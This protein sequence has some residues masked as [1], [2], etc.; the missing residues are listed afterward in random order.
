MKTSTKKLKH[1]HIASYYTT[2]HPITQQ[3]E[4]RKKARDTLMHMLDL[5]D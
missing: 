2:K 1:F 5:L 3:N 4:A